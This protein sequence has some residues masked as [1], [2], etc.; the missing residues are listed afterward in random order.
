MSVAVPMAGGGTV[1][2][3]ECLQLGRFVA[4]PMPGPTG[5]LMFTE[6]APALALVLARDER[7]TGS[8]WAAAACVGSGLFSAGVAHGCQNALSRIIMQTCA[9]ATTWQLREQCQTPT[10]AIN[11]AWP[12]TSWDT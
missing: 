4:M 3:A 7:G 10:P 6:L 8:T 12:Q 5:E 9:R 11:S 2:G 1:L